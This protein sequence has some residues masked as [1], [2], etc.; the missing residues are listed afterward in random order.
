L[1]N[2]GNWSL[3]WQLQTNWVDEIAGDSNGWTHSGRGDEWHVS[4]QEVH[5]EPYAWYCGS[6]EFESY[7]N[8]VDSSLVTPDV[9]LGAGP[10]LSFW[11]WFR[12]EYDGRSG[13]EDCFWDGGVVDISTNGGSSFER[14]VPVGG[15][16]Y[17]I[18]P[19]DD[20]PFPDDM[21]CLAGTGGW[22]QVR[23]DLADYAGKTV[24]IRFRFGS[25]LYTVERGWFV[26]DVALEWRGSW[27]TAETDTGVV[28]Q[29][30]SVDLPLV[31]DASNLALGLH[32]NSISL[33]CS[34]PTNA[35][36]FVTVHA[37]VVH[38]KSTQIGMDPADS[39]AFVISW[40][41]DSSHYYSL[42]S[43]TNLLDGAWAG[44]PGYTNLPGVNGLMS[45]TGMLQNAEILFYRVDE[46]SD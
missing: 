7:D 12:S 5:S 38:T 16:P 10:V 13:Y 29:Y 19:N 14:I 35:L 39:G 15:Y 32:H 37:R 8:D 31:V 41:A 2:S 36:L 6:D 26:D 45:Y 24:K 9:T 22:E 4:Q 33:C 44:V 28:P 1:V 11:Q 46:R 40:Q 34:D 3:D 21:P 27:L 20:S 43:S 18:T 23:F 17:K 42:M 25:D 30:A